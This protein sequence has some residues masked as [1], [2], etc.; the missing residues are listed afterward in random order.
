MKNLFIVLFL[1][2]C[3][4]SCTKEEIQDTIKIQPDFVSTLT[5]IGVGDTVKFKNFTKNALLNDTASHYQ[6]HFEG[7]IPEYSSSMEGASIS[8][9]K[10]VIYGVTLYLIK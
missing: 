3:I 4:I 10:A 6:W 8:Y 2:L 1:I 5:T 7:G 9:K